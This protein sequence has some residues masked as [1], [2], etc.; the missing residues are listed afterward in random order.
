MRRH[1]F[2]SPINNPELPAGAQIQTAVCGLVLM[3]AVDDDGALPLAV[4]HHLLLLL[5]NKR[6][7]Q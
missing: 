2:R 1:W 5:N 7:L 4:H 6:R 3:F